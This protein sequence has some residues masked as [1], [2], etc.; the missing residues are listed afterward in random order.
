MFTQKS[1]LTSVACPENSAS[2]I[3]ILH[4]DVDQ[5]DEFIHCGNICVVRRSEPVTS[6]LLPGYAVRRAPHFT[7]GCRVPRARVQVTA[8]C[9]HG[10]YPG[11]VSVVLASE[12]CPAEIEDSL[13][14]E[15]VLA[16]PYLSAL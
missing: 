16:P 11:V 9:S 6:E 13:P 7:S 10:C 15:P 12:I 8:A 2:R 14:C 3:C 1:L 4:A 5:T